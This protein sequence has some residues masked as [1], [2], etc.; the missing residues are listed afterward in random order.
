MTAVASPRSADLLRTIVAGTRRV[1][2][3]RQSV[4]SFAVLAEKAEGVL[5]RP[6]VFGAALR[7]PGVRV[8]AECK[9]RSPSR[10][11]PRALY[12]PAV[13][14]RGYVEAGAAAISV[15]TEP[16]FFDGSVEHLQQI[17][18]AV[19]VPVLRKDFIVSEYQ[20]L[21]ARA[22]GADA[23]LLIVAAVSPGELQALL[24][25]AGQFGLDALVEVHDREELDVA[26]DAGARIVGVNNRNLRTLA[27]DIR[28]SEDL[29]ALMP[30]DVLAVSES[31][32]KTSDDLEALSRL[33]FHAFLIGEGLMMQPDPAAALRRLLDAG[34]D[35]PS[36]AVRSSVT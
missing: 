11:V 16:M 33:G 26:I 32:L 29:I 22:A 20:L 18:Q 23:V 14:A 30:R 10:G 31:G 5:P 1:V 24:H 35:R 8:I 27:V 25:R 15:L 17:R 7:Q 36:A 3:V 28:A 34:S 6:G 2:E 12:E 4:E 21:E 9:R 13:I 19:D